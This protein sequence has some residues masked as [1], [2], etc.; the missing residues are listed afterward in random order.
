M[1]T[2]LPAALAIAAVLLAP[3]AA[4]AQSKAS[5]KTHVRQFFVS[6]ADAMGVPVE[7]LTTADFKV[8]EGGEGRAVSRVGSANPPMRI[9][10]M[11]DT[12][13][14]TAPALNNMRTAVAGF[15]DS[16]RPDDEVLVITT[17]RQVSVRLQPTTDRQKVK[18]V[19]AGLFNDGGGTRLMEGLL[20]VDERF[21]RKAEDRWPVFVIFTSDGLEIS[22]SGRENEFKKW[23]LALGTRGVSAHALVLKTP[24]GR[25]LPEAV[26]VAEIVAENLTQ[27]TG[28]DYDTMNTTAV[29][30][31]KMK[32]LSQTLARS[33]RNM[34]GWYALD[35]QTPANEARPID[36]TVARQGVAVRT[37]DRRDSR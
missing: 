24:K 16:L 36:V 21:F 4:P 17:G 19:A 11:L 15:G 7:G 5:G 10:L 26:G 34:S 33:H 14:G 35:I 8:T 29:L 27:N 18:D 28:G 22:S 2:L 1:K 6:V 3:S 9:A 12:S 37:T 31:E 23:A 13:Q 30:P 25:D 32:A 20:E